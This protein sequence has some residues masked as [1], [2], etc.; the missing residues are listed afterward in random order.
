MAAHCRQSPGR[1]SLSHHFGVSISRPHA[2]SHTCSPPHFSVVLG[3]PP[4][5]P[6]RKCI[7]RPHLSIGRPLAA[8]PHSPASPAFEPWPALV[9]KHTL[10]LALAKRQRGPRFTAMV[11]TQ[12]SVDQGGG[13]RARGGRGVGVVGVAGD[14]GVGGREEGGGGLAWGDG[15]ARGPSPWACMGARASLETTAQNQ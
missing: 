10:P 2:A 1:G 7:A 8:G 5:A 14:R 4:V 15:A 11:K 3:V 12:H 9:Q 13:G 6:P